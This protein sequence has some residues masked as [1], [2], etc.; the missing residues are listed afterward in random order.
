[1]KQVCIFSS[2]LF[3]LSL[4]AQPH[5]TYDNH[6]DNRTTIRVQ[7][8]LKPDD[9]LYSDYFAVSVNNPTVTIEDWHVTPHSIEQFDSDFKDIKKINANNPTLEITAHCTNVCDAVIHVD[10]YQKSKKMLES[11]SIPLHLDPSQDAAQSDIQSDN[12]VQEETVAAPNERTSSQPPEEKSWTDR[13]EDLLQSTNSLWI[14]MLFALLLGLLLSLTPCIYPMIPITVGIL[15][16]QGAQS[17]LRNFLVSCSYTTGIATTFALLGLSAAFT[18]QLF[19]SL[20]GNPLFVV[21]IV[22]VLLYL[23]GSMIGLYEMYIPSFLTAGNT[24]YKGGS[25]LSTFVFG[26]VTGTIASPCLSPGLVLLLT[27]VTT[28]G[29]KLIGFLILFAF[30]MG[31]GIPLLIIGTFSGSMNVLPSAGMWMVE[32]KKF[33]GFIMIGMCFFYLNNVV[34]WSILSWAVA[35]TVL[36]AGIFYFDQ[37]KTVPGWHKRYNLLGTLLI[38]SSLWLFFKAYQANHPIAQEEMVQTETVSPWYTDFDAALQEAKT[39]NK[40]LFVKIGAPYCGQCKTIDK[41]LLAN[42]DVAT[43][44]TTRFVPFIIDNAGENSEHKRLQQEWHVRGVPTFF[45]IDPNT[46]KRIHRFGSEIINWSS[47]KFIA[48]LKDI[49]KS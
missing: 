24:T 37:A 42:K 20:L 2:L 22:L 15:Q 48:M 44:I 21:G 35:A 12:Q 1:V 46:G 28:I 6:G 18:G 43:L 27:L 9:L 49:K 38:A 29:S 26:A 40:L 14:R 33:F 30:G 45:I 10:Y 25:L 16:A 32:V 19:G 41:T 11:L 13:I 47:S 23:A 8:D 17:V 36:A 31:L 3:F 7:F 4:N 34:S 39:H 5:I